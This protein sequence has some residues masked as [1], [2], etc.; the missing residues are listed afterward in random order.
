MAGAGQR[1]HALIWGSVGTTSSFVG[2][3]HCTERQ[4]SRECRGRWETGI[5]RDQQVERHRAGELSGDDRHG[6]P[7]FGATG[8]APYTAIAADKHASTAVLSVKLAQVATAGLPPAPLSRPLAA[9]LRMSGSPPPQELS[10]AS[11]RAEAPP[12]HPAQS[13]S[14]R[15]IPP[16][17]SRHPPPR[18]ERSRSRS[19]TRE[20]RPPS[21]TYTDPTTRSS[22]SSKAS[23]PA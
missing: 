17:K 18:R 16:A 10:P 15:P 13:R 21:S 19:P 11:P 14:R 2:K 4:H 5:R 3:C 6:D 1:R 12:H 7:Q 22:A 8:P 23:A 9:C 20:P